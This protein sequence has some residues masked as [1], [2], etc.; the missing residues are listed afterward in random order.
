MREFWDVKSVEETLGVLRRFKPVGTDVVRLP[1]ALGRVLAVDVSSAEDIP[2]FDRSMVDGYAVRAED[3]AG[4]SE[5]SPVELRVAGEV[6]MAQTADFALGTGE[7]AEVPTGGMVP[8][9][10]D[11]VVMVEYTDIPRDGYVAVSKA[12]VPGERVLKRGKDIACG[13]VILENGTLLAPRHLGMLAAVG[14]VELTVYRTVRVAVISTG[15]EL[16]P[17]DETPPLGKVRDINTTVLHAALL[18]DGAEPMIMGLVPD[19][20]TALRDAVA[21]ALDRSDFV[22]VS[23]GSSVGTRDITLDIIE[24]FDDSEVFVHGVKMRPGKPTIL[25]RVANKPVMGLP[26]HPASVT[27]CYSVIV[28]PLLRRLAGHSDSELVRYIDRHK[29]VVTA[30]LD[31]NV[32]SLI[33]REDR[34]RVSLALED[35]LLVASPIYGP[36]GAISTVGKADGWIVIDANTEGYM[37]GQ[38]VEVELI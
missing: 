26:G 3:A 9:G 36:S 23:A 7:A 15:D 20:E 32:A 16:V 18:E 21:S 1:D 5:S 28:R 17:P 27:V 19:D 2:A 37:K 22:L 6:F 33:G 12:V 38:P 11:A 29:G 25:A 30:E 24:S 35:G 8:E 34:L 13:E 4:A 10:A 14:V 31:R